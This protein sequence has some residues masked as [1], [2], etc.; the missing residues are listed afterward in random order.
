MEAYHNHDH[1]ADGR[2]TQYDIFE[3]ESLHSQIATLP[4]SLNYPANGASHL[5]RAGITGGCR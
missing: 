3:H 2:F 4:E 5:Y 1:D